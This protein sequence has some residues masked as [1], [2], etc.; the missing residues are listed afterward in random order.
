MKT[1]KCPVCG[2]PGIPDYLNEDVVCP[3]CGSDLKIY[4]TL[5]EVS[6][7]GDASA[8]SAKKYKLLAIILPIIA[9]LL[10][11]IPFFIVHN[12]SQN[13]HKTELAER[14]ANICALRDSVKVLTAQLEKPAEAAP[15]YVEYTVVRNDGPWRI[16]KKAI[17]DTGN[18]IEDYKQI[19]KDNGFWDEASSTWKMIHPGQILKIYKQK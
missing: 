7:T 6:N 3:H 10:V 9:I 1:S 18:W 12:N 2:N 17:G 5:A 11:G 14:D 13:V 8:G 15:D 16:V 4:K 19:A